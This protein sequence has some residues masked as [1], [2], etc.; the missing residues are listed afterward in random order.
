MKNKFLTGTELFMIF[1]GIC[2]LVKLLGLTS[3]S[4]WWFGLPLWCFL[5]T[6]VLSSILY[7]I[8][9]MVVIIWALILFIKGN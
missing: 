7:I 6:C 8:V 9:L 5:G 3:I 2:I 1:W 4:W